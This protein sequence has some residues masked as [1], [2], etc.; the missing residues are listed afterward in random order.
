MYKEDKFSAVSTQACFEIGSAISVYNHEIDAWERHN[1]LAKLAANN[2]VDTVKR[3]VNYFWADYIEFAEAHLMSTYD[4][5]S[6]LSRQAKDAHKF[7]NKALSE[8]WGIPVKVLEIVEHGVSC[9]YMWSLRFKYKGVNMVLE[10]P[11]IPELTAHKLSTAHEGKLAIGTVDKDGDI[12][13]VKTSYSIK[14]FVPVL[15]DMAKA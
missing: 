11:N 6:D 7:L 13:I 12:T 3:C 9:C 4:K 14:S 2:A 15:N 5:E 1:L 8:A 10:V